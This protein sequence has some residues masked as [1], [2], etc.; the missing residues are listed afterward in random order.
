MKK[1]KNDCNKKYDG[2]KNWDIF[3]V[4]FFLFDLHFIKNV[5]NSLFFYCNLVTTQKL[6]VQFP[7]P[8][9]QMWVDSIN[10][11]ICMAPD[12]RMQVQITCFTHSIIFFRR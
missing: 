8:T 11:V 2:D 4:I 5:G 6:R 10:L 3:F 12:H 7:P 1:K 9:I